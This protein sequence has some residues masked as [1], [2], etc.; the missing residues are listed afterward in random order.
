MALFV[1]QDEERSEIQKKVATG[2][3]NKAKTGT[4]KQKDTEPALLEN[5]HQTRP[6]GVIISLFV[7]AVIVAAVVVFFI[8]Q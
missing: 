7:I 5:E 2:L 1:R 3:K 4:I 6:A 8:N